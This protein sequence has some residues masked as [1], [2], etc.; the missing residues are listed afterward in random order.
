[1]SRR[2]LWLIG[3][4]LFL[5]LIGLALV[6]PMHM[7]R[8]HDEVA[9]IA[10]E[11]YDSSLEA[12]NGPTRIPVC[13]RG[14]WGYVNEQGEIVVPLRFRSVGDFTHNRAPARD[15]GLFGY[16]NQSGAWVIEPTWD[17]A[18]PFSEGLAVVYFDDRASVIDTNGRVVFS[19]DQA[20][21]G[22]FEGG[23]AHVETDS[24]S[25]LVT[26]TGRFLA[27]PGHD[28]AIMDTSRILVCDSPSAPIDQRSPCNWR[29]IDRDGRTIRSY[30]NVTHVKAVMGIPLAVLFQRTTSGYVYALIV[31][32]S[33]VARDVL[34]YEEAMMFKGVIV[35]S[36]LQE[37]VGSGRRSTL[38]RL[39]KLFWYWPKASSVAR[40]LRETR[41]I[42]IG[43]G[44]VLGTDSRIVVKDPWFSSATRLRFLAKS[45]SS[46]RQIDTMWVDSVVSFHKDQIVVTIHDTMCVVAADGSIVWRGRN[47]AS[48]EHERD[49]AYQ[50]DM[51]GSFVSRE[52]E[53]L[54]PK[55]VNQKTSARLTFATQVDGLDD[56]HLITEHRDGNS[57]LLVSIVNRMSDT[58]W[59]GRSYEG[60]QMFLEA[61]RSPRYTWVRVEELSLGCGLGQSPL[62]IPPN[63]FIRLNREAY[64]GAR[65]YETRLA[66]LVLQESDRWRGKTK[67]CY[68]PI[69]LSK[70]NPAQ[71]YRPS[72][73]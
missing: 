67:M 31:D 10:P 11:Q 42:L 57:K 37:I 56:V 51:Y 50:G 73:R 47:R 26:S 49:I 28:Y 46:V 19:C 1:M 59:L 40:L 36:G 17:L 38:D 21:I 71:F 62:P 39:S 68:S 7:D 58:A 70:L 16:I 45:N 14:M 3:V 8:L 18:M 29:L 4:A 13:E 24:G 34:S 72:Y 52:G 32:H 61:R 60:V 55:N 6:L 33:G 43:G 63:Q 22:P 27:I 69:F 53:D 66:F 2:S 20:Y 30:E 54:L 23:L 64:H 15:T 44:V 65:T 25:G 41:G 35:R 5:A 12:G 9:A 48:S